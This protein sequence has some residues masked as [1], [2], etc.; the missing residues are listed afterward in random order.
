M[1]LVKSLHELKMAGF[2]LH[3]GLS[4]STHSHTGSPSP[5]GT[6]TWRLVHLVSVRG[7]PRLWSGRSG[8]LKCV[9]LGTLQPLSRAGGFRTDFS[10]R[11]ATVCAA[12]FLFV[13][14]SL[15]CCSFDASQWVLRASQGPG[16]PGSETGNEHGR[17]VGTLTHLTG[18]SVTLGHGRVCFNVHEAAK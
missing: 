13:G 17:E 1:E 9:R 14:D 6:L 16:G 2:D 10:C 5:A 18:T 4:W 3:D 12:C 11:C 7:F 15:S 8:Q